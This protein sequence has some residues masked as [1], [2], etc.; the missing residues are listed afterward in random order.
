MIKKS[1]SLIKKN[2]EADSV[3]AVEKT[4]IHPG[5]IW[6]IK[7]K[8]I[9]PILKKYNKR[10]IP[11]HSCQYAELPTFYAQNASLETIKKESFEKYKIISGKKILPLITNSLE[12]FDINTKIDYELAK[13]IFNKKINLKNI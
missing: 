12:G 8:F 5:K 6:E 13:L 1:I 11:W 3:R 4:T 2:N 7:K 9:L 10:S